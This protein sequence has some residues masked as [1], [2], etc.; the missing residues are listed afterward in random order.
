M[1]SQ[2]WSQL[3][4][5]QVLA[6]HLIRTYLYRPKTDC[7]FVQLLRFDSV[8]LL[9]ASHFRSVY[10]RPSED[11]LVLLLCYS[12]FHGSWK[13]HLWLGWHLESSLLDGVN[14][15]D[16]VVDLFSTSWKCF[17]FGQGMLFF[18]IG[19]FL[20]YVCLWVQIKRHSWRLLKA[21]RSVAR[22]RQCIARLDYHCCLWFPSSK[23]QL[24]ARLEKNTFLN[25]F[26][27]RFFLLLWKTHF[28]RSNSS[29]FFGHSWS[30][31]S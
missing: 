6:F 4:L 12:S 22:V 10:I 17:L 3:A 27:R 11:E 9:L 18:S 14:Y 19:C 23:A 1:Q 8:I 16:K 13:V 28:I 25:H 5:K 26:D 7:F 24:F 21:L 31:S 29:P 30:W 15:L 20:V 2:E